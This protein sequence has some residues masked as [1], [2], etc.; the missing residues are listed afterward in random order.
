MTYLAAK[1]ITI[2]GQIVGVII[3]PGL[4]MASASFAWKAKAFRTHEP[5]H[6][7][8]CSSGFLT[9]VYNNAAIFG[10]GALEG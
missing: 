6:A 9:L 1:V 10:M 7:R 3:S 5:T 2:A 8:R 4:K